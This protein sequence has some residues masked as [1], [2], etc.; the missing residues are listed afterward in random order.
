MELTAALDRLGTRARPRV[1]HAGGALLGSECNECGRLSWPG[2]AICQ[3]CGSAD[4]H[5]AALA[6][7]G[8]LI[9]FSTVRVPRP[10]LETPYE[11]GQVLLAD[12]VRVFGHLRSMAEPHSGDPVRLVVAD[13]QDAVPPYWFE[14]A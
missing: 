12:G 8:E 9:T 2:R 3:T 5:D 11:L 10:G 14:P 1:D 7:E 6:R 13:A 4:V